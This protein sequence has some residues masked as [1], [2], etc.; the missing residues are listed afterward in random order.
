MTMKNITRNFIY[1]VSCLLILLRVN[2]L[3]SG[4]KKQFL[5]FCFLI[6]SG[7]VNASA[8]TGI[9]TLTVD[10]AVR[11]ALEKNLS[12]KRQAIDLG[13]KKRTSDRSWNTLI[14]NVTAG[15]SLSHPTSLTGG[16]P[17]SQN[18]WTP[19]VSVSASLSLSAGIINNI[20]KTKID[21]E[22]G[23]LSYQQAWQDLELS[24]RKLFYQIILLEVNRE[25]A[26][27]S[28]AS[29]QERYEQSAAFAKTGQV[30][31]LEE[32][33]ARVDMENQRPN[34]RNAETVYENA[35]DFFKT[36]LDIPRE[37]VILLDGSLQLDDTSYLPDTANLSGGS[38]LET[39]AVKNSILSLREQRNA[40]RNNTYIPYLRLSW[41]STSLYNINGKQWND[42]TGSFSVTLGFGLESLLPWSQ[43]RTQIDS[44]NDN[45]RSAEILLSE[46]I[47]NSESRIVQLLR[48]IQQTRETITALSLNVEL[49]Q[50][51]YGLYEEAWQH[52]EVDYQQLRDAGDSLLQAQNRVKQEQYNLIAAI[53][54]LEKELNVP[55]G[56]IK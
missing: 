8:Q 2:A 22:A 48:T 55:F 6:F 56:S 4:R 53:L 11:I 33:K 51:A 41:N 32:M 54:D 28:L 25:L 49:A 50:T 9:Q 30:S 16:I 43:A 38:S 44:F 42:N 3:L 24:V 45:I 26:A 27:Q 1:P 46:T 29:A 21:Y 14:P 31:M 19:G 36:L 12:L 15:A 35:L 39:A 34:V 23:E 40:A 13:G 5:I 20:K 7:I 17:E 18:V 47:R 37:Q 52:G 10:E